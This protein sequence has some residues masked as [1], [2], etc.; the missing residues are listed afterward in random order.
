M[1]LT[2]QQLRILNKNPLFRSL[3]DEQ[4]AQ[5]KSSISVHAFSQ[6]EHLFTQGDSAEAF[7]LVLSGRI[8]LYRLAPS[9]QEK[10]IELVNPGQTFAEALMFQEVPSYPLNAQALGDCE[11]VVIRSKGFLELLSGSV[12]L[13]F[14]VMASLSVRLR[15]LLGEI[16]A[17]TLQN[18]GLRVANYLIHLLPEGCGDSEVVTLPAAKNI[19]AS[20]LSIQPET[21]SRSLHALSGKGLIE[22][23]GLNIRVLDIEALRTY[24]A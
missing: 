16:D 20:R 8:R 21:L 9:G 3:D 4:L 6:G 10:V 1:E 5:L 11:V 15:R 18:S 24:T 12:D 23:D 7:F 14:K 13:C 19:I 2:L 22:V 17:L